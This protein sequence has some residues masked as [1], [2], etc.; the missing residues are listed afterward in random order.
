MAIR[1]R[2]KGWML[3]LYLGNGERRRFQYN[4]TREEARIIEQQL[5]KEHNRPLA[6]T[7]TIESMSPEY[8]EYVSVYQA[9]RTFIDKKK[10]LVKVVDF[11]GRYHPDNITIN[12]ID[13]YK[14]RRLAEKTKAKHP[15]HRMINMELLL[16]SALIKWA[17]EH[18][19]CTNPPVRI[20]Q[21]PYKRPMPRP[22]T[23]EET[24]SFLEVLPVEK[25]LI[26]LIMTQG[27]LRKSE[28]T[29]LT[30]DRVD[31]EA[32]KLVIKGKG[33]K[34]RIVYLTQ[35]VRALLEGLTRTSDLVFPSRKTGMP[36]TDLRGAIKAA[37]EAAGITKKVTPHLL[38]HGFATHLLQSGVDLRTIQTLLGHAKITTTEIY[39]HVSSEMLSDAIDALEKNYGTIKAQQAQK[40]ESENRVTH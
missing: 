18:G 14:R 12:L 31:L 24:R 29:G 30:W 10:M 15:I 23:L 25:R 7:E 35:E 38:R 40:S 11:F 3:D 26:F 4:G 2:G 13:D 27:G 36:I 28:A 34:E 6:S 22:L 17:Y 8:L 19:K 16:L 5:L 9:A 33:S 37:K 20:K 39:T 32:G 21:L 1:K